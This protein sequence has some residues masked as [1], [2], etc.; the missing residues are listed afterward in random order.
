MSSESLLYQ[1]SSP[2]K[3]SSS[4]NKKHKWH[5]GSCF[6]STN[7]DRHL[8]A[9]DHPKTK[10]VLNDVAAFSLARPTSKRGPKGLIYS[11]YLIFIYTSIDIVQR[12]IYLL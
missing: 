3:R 11:Y 5:T 2:T 12:N 10:T 9:G 6:D 4:P 1:A 8:K 7:V